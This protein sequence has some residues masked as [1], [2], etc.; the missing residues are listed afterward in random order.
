MAG[1]GPE[2]QSPPVAGT[3]AGTSVVELGSSIA[4]EVVKIGPPGGAATRDRPPTQRGQGYFFTYTHS[5]KKSLVLDPRRQAI[6][7]FASCGASAAPAL[8]QDEMLGEPQTAACC[9]RFTVTEDGGTWPRLVSPL[10]RL[11]TPPAVRAPMPVLGR[12]NPA[13]LATVRRQTAPS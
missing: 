12:D 13:I 6:A 11:G 10:S 4:A 5:D 7:R 1:R 3:P 8:T 2:E 9:L